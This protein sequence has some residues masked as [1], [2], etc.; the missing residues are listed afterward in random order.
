MYSTKEVK[1]L[2]EGYAELREAKAT[3]GHGLFVLCLLTDLDSAIK[4]MPP[5]EYQAVLLHGQLRHT[6]RDAEQILEVARSTLSDRYER[7]IAWI[8]KYLNTGETE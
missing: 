7:G 2:I 6:V 5:K 8:T 1:G 4:L 3:Y